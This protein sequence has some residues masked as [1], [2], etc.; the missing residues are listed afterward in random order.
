MLEL[1]DTG[2]FTSPWIKFIKHLLSS[3]GFSVNWYS[4]CCVNSRGLVKAV[5]QKLKDVFIQNWLSKINIESKSN[6]YR[7]FKSSF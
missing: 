7:C 6:I 1:H 2:K 3:S 5:N 4:H